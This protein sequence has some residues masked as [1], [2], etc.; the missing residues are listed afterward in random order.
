MSTEIADNNGNDKRGLSDLEWIDELYQ[1]LQGN[2]VEHFKKGFSPKLTPT[3]AFHIIWFLQEHL[4]VLPDTIERCGHCDEL[5]DTESE[6]RHIEEPY[7]GIHNFCG[8]C[9]EI[10]PEK[11]LKD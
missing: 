9:L 3:K 4:R 8:G 5:Y 10:V 6:G 1:Y 7:K 2:P 11:H